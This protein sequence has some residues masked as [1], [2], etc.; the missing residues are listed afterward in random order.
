[1]S[2]KHDKRGRSKGNLGLFFAIEIFILKTPAWRSLSPVARSIYVEVGSL[3]NQ[4]NN[5]K[6]ALSARQV[7]LHMPISRATATRGFKELVDKGFLVACRQSGFNMKTGE[8][9]ATEWQ[10]TRFKCDVTGALPSK[11]FMN[12][13][14]NKIKI[15]ASPQSQSGFIAEPPHP[16]IVENRAEVA[17]TRSRHDDFQKHDGFI[18]VPLIESYHMGVA[19]NTAVSDGAGKPMAR[20]LSDDVIINNS[21]DTFQIFGAVALKSLAQ[22]EALLPDELKSW[23]PIP[24]KQNLADAA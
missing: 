1:M 8:R 4:S 2:G 11:A 13:R 21:D 12:W 24:L 22:L 15:A 18:T 20:V 14:P 9:K 17:P 23:S 5:G 3:Y 7:A 6:L 10:L 16:K 19:T